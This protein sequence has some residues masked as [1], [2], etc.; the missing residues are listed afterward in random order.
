[1]S[2][3][4]VIDDEP[5][6]RNML[7]KSLTKKGYEVFSAEDGQMGLD[8]LQ[9]ENPSVIVLDLRM[10]NVDGIQ[11]LEMVQPKIDTPYSVI[12]LTGNETD[13]D[14]ERC[15]ELGVCSF[16][17][18]PVNLY[19]LHGV[20]RHHMDL[21]NF[22]EK[23]KKEITKKEEANQLILGIFNGMEEA[24]VCLDDHYKIKMLSKKA[25][26]MLGVKETD[27]L[28]QP[29]AKILGSP[30]AGPSGIL[31]QPTNEKL[32]ETQLLCPSGEILPVTLKLQKLE[33][34]GKGE[35]QWLLFIDNQR[36]R[37]RV[38]LKRTRGTKFGRMISA[39]PKMK[40]IFELIDDV[41]SSNATVLIQGESGTGK[42]L[43]AKEIHDRSRRAQKTFHAVNCA[44]INPSLLESEF[45]GHEQG[46]FTG[47][48]K[49]KIGRFEHASGGT[50]FL[51]E[52]G[53]IP[54]DL[55][56]K[57]LRALQERSFERVGGVNAVNVDVRIIAATNKNLHEMVQQ[58]TFR[59]DLYYRLDVVS[60]K[61]PA[62]REHIQ[63]VSLLISFF[64]EELNQK[65][66]RDVIDID[67]E[68]LQILNG[69][70]WPGNVRE[71]FHVIEYAFA[72]SKD[73]TI[74]CP[75]HL[76]EKVISILDY[77][78]ETSP[79]S[80]KELILDALIKT[81]YRISKTASILGVSTATLYRKR[82]KYSI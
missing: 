63:D 38:M 65:E 14:V 40:K 59:E 41:A 57:L 71:L 54:L 69:Y 50:L 70:A 52:V 64:I 2:R 78:E 26:S 73:S 47:A 6:V 61:T 75:E 3:I 27:A 46:A 20:V 62:L 45:F 12:V 22:S 13:E 25:C 19:E 1:M 43:V 8:I 82:K 49:T 39:D 68:I 80:E 32:I 18:K 4:L 37:E 81:G 76:P 17:R 28:E 67:P 10:P 9:K 60:I 42:E 77:E 11:F 29:A 23:L 5:L 35:P 74:L 30:I 7:K 31:M 33:Y 16:L 15:Y 55:Q 53:E 66:E 44:A 56:V 34:S 24:V 72:V 51:D 36:D 58:G 48:Q 79:K 21:L